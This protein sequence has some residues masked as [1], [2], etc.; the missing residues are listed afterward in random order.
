MKIN[1]NSAGKTIDLSYLEGLSSG[2]KE[3]VREMKDLFLSE[4]P[5]E[6]K[7]LEKAISEKNHKAIQTLAHKLRSTIP[8]MGLDKIIEKDV[9]EIETL[10]SNMSD[11][12]EIEKRFS[13]IKETCEKAYYE[14]N[15]V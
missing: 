13:K 14:L 7:S 1:T 4:N 8:F 11:I 3:F 10:A 6:I 2:N 15:P 12:K 9:T 5:E